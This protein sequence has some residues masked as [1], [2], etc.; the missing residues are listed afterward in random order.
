MSQLILGVHSGPHDGAAAVFDDYGL[1]AAVSLERL[2]RKKGDGS[3]HPDAAIDEVLLI[4]GATR[5]DVDVVCYSRT[6]FPTG[7]FRDLSA[8]RW[9]KEQ[10]RTHIQ[11]KPRIH[12]MPELL[13]H[14]TADIDTFFDTARLQ[15]EG[16]FRRDAR[17]YFYN[18]HE[19]HALPALFYSPWDE[20]LLVTA[21]GGGDTVHYSHRHLA[22]GVLTTIYGGEE[23]ILIPAEEDSLGKMYGAATKALGFQRSRHEGKVTGL[24]AMGHP[25]RA[26]EL[27]QNF[28]VDEAGRVHSNL[29]SERELNAR[30][31]E[32]LRGLCREDYAASAQNVL[33]DVML[34]SVERLLSRYPARNLGLSGGVFANVTLNRKL[35]EKLP[36][37]EVFIFP[38]MGDD[39]LAV[40]GALAWLLKRD[41][42]K[43]WLH[44]REPLQDL[45]FGRDYDHEIDRVL[46]ASRGVRRLPTSP[47]DGAAELLTHGQI[48]AVYT[49]R[50]EFGPRALGA[51]SI[52]ANPSRRET[53]D[54]LNKRLERSDFMPFAPVVAEEKA[55]K[56]F[57]ISSVNAR[58]CRYMTITCNVRSGWRARIPAVVHVDHSARPQTITRPINPLYY[59][60]LASFE[61]AND[62]PVLVNTSFNVHEEPIVNTPEECMHALV[63]GRIDFVATDR[64]LYERGDGGAAALAS[65]L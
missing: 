40:G 65:G 12:M 50:M 49:H 34:T 64:A 59:D 22:D 42:L 45:Y 10:Y 61:R 46:T 44:R 47:A 37:D 13:R 24:A 53:H 51:R 26:A 55:R 52:L 11:R 63:D 2:T 17:V 6:M 32:L 14:N 33:E 19:A 20:A 18:H 56:V 41:G 9:L 23:R 31:R 29:R 36:L 39:G 7:Y 25:L 27:M 4:A 15:K 58:A 48:G 5:Q 16:R 28:S 62:L 43:T 30:M 1:K 54:L 57:D 8:A 35:A 60:I 21:D 3:R 38:A